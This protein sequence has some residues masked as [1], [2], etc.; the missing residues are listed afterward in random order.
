M[1]YLKARKIMGNIIDKQRNGDIENSPRAVHKFVIAMQVV[2]RRSP[3]D[4]GQLLAGTD[5]V[6]LTMIFRSDMPIEG[7]C[8]DDSDDDEYFG[9]GMRQ[10]RK[11]SLQYHLIPLLKCLVV[12][13]RQG[14][15]KDVYRSVISQLACDSK[16]FFCSRLSHVLKCLAH[17]LAGIPPGADANTFPDG[18]PVSLV[19]AF[20]ESLRLQPA[21]VTAGD[22]GIFRNNFGCGQSK[23][24]FTT[25][26]MD[27]QDNLDK[28]NEL[29]W[30][31][32][33]I[34]ELYKVLLVF[35]EEIVHT[36]GLVQRDP[37]WRDF[38]ACLGDSMDVCVQVAFGDHAPGAGPQ[39]LVRLETHDRHSHPYFAGKY[40]I[41]I[42]CPYKINL[43]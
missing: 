42:L 27:F 6:P 40:A 2:A 21:L 38:L 28:Y 20:G 35:V 10:N 22:L 1:Q 24:D 4:L 32:G 12:D 8:G 43:V 41:C 14:Q 16:S 30:E 23:C 34:F 5:Y 33:N 26:K 17:A 39:I 3:M 11:L 15:E 18:V 19:K 25:N 7:E 9:Y 13:L 36:L 31:P 37:E 29:I